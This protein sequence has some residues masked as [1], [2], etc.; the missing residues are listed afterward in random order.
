MHLDDDQADED[1]DCQD[2]DDKDDSKSTAAVH[3]D[4]TQKPVAD[5]CVIVC[6]FMQ[7]RGGHVWWWMGGVRMDSNA[8]GRPPCTQPNSPRRC[9]LRSFL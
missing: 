3:A 6:E 5:Y 9:K 8:G 1:D 2:T 7:I 4:C